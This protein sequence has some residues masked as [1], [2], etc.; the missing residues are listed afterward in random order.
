MMALD[1][2]QPLITMKR[3]FYPK[4]WLQATGYFEHH[5]NFGP[6]VILFDSNPES[7]NTGSG[8]GS[9]SG[10]RVVA[11]ILLTSVLS[12]VVTA[13]AVMFYLQQQGKGLMLLP[14]GGSGGGGSAARVA[15]H[16]YTPINS[17]MEL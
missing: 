10:V 3:I 5:G 9:G 16:E 11:G 4:W 6:G 15:R 2:D 1:R 7:V 14:G 8:S 17:D 12:C 13:A